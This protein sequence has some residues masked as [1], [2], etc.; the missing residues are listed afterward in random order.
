MHAWGCW[1]GGGSGCS[2]ISAQFALLKSP[3]PDA[4]SPTH[5]KRGNAYTRAAYLIALAAII[6]IMDAARSAHG[7]SAVHAFY[8]VSFQWNSLL[9]TLINVLLVVVLALPLLHLLAL[10]P[11]VP[12]LGAHVLE[13]W[14]ILGL[15]GTATRSLGGAVIDVV[16]SS[17]L[18]MPAYFTAA[19]AYANRSDV[20]VASTAMLVGACG[21]VIG[22]AYVAAA[23]ETIDDFGLLRCVG[24]CAHKRE[25]AP[26]P[27]H[28]EVPRP[29]TRP[30]P[31]PP[32]KKGGLALPH[33][34][35]LAAVL[36]PGRAGLWQRLLADAGKPSVRV[37]CC[38][39]GHG[40]QRGQ[41]TVPFSADVSCPYS[42]SASVATCIV[43]WTA[44]LAR[45]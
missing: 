39:S 22:A 26:S 45:V 21:L 28:K 20:S 44:V 11:H 16:R 25:I 29:L 35:R 23:C 42:R 36:A 37:S 12:T 43:A 2:H 41:G 24:R 17:I 30:R 1:G 34:S 8:G 15:G 27:S 3:Q 7:A 33:S 19:S 9:T 40:G 31:P 13:Q 4:A 10:L 32:K 18:L 38:A 5:F 14:I 6:L